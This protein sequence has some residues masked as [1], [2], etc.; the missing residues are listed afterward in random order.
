MSE[1]EDFFLGLIMWTGLIVVIIASFTVPPLT[2]LAIL[3]LFGVQQ[4]FTVW[5]VTQLL[6][7]TL[8]ILV[9]KNNP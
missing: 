6:W 3:W 5:L 8:L 2:L 7:A 1:D 9:S 4:L